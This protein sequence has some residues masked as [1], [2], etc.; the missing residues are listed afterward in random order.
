MADCGVL[1]S[2]D[3]DIDFRLIGNTCEAKCASREIAMVLLTNTE[4]HE[5]YGPYHKAALVHDIRYNQR[6]VTTLMNVLYA[7]KIS[8]IPLFMSLTLNKTTSSALRLILPFLG[9]IIIFCITC[10]ILKIIFNNYT[11]KR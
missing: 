6:T 4:H 3:K 1:K 11:C 7:E 9:D 8:L 5:N 2:A 10:S